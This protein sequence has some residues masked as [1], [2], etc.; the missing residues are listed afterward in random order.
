MALGTLLSRGPSA[1]AVHHNRCCTKV[2]ETID[3]MDQNIAIDATGEPSKTYSTDIVV[4]LITAI[5]VFLATGLLEI[6]GQYLDVLPTGLTLRFGA[7]KPTIPFAVGLV[8]M[9]T[10]A[11]TAFLYVR[12]V[13]RR[14]KRGRWQHVMMPV[15]LAAFC[16]SVV[17]LVRLVVE[18]LALTNS[19]PKLSAFLPSL[20]HWWIVLTC[21][22]IVF[23]IVSLIRA[24]KETS[25]FRLLWWIVG[26]GI[27]AVLD[28]SACNRFQ[29]ESFATLTMLSG[30]GFLLVIVS[31]GRCNGGSRQPWTKAIHRPQACRTVSCRQRYC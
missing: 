6:L 24:R 5:I 18:G 20:P 29:T 16:L 8:S 2:K 25:A 4:L 26:L 14:R 11:G 10:I 27:L 22:T 28:W 9:A 19:E 15:S 3:I 13:Q 1:V 17:V 12:T 7:I 21:V 30:L 23:A 31:K